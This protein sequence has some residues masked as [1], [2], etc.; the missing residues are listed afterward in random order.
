MLNMHIANHIIMYLTI[1]ISSVLAAFQDFLYANQIL[2]V[3]AVPAMISDQSNV[4]VVEGQ[5]INLTCQASGDPVS[6]ATW[7]ELLSHMY[8]VTNFEHTYS[9]ARTI[10]MRKHFNYSL[11]TSST[12]SGIFI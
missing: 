5:S 6:S 12:T 8:V 4:T 3:P 1:F 2:F 11:L 7:H 9:E 10:L